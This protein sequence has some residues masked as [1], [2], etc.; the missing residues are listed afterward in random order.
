MSSPAEAERLLAKAPAVLARYSW[1]RAAD[2]T[3]EHLE[4]IAA[5]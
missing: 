2:R 3:L 4:R 1:D 5:R